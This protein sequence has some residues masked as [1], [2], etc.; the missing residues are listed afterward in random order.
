M[1]FDW[2]EFDGLEWLLALAIPIAAALTAMWVFNALMISRRRDELRQ[3]DENRESEYS[4]WCEGVRAHGGI[5]PVFCPVTLEEG[6]RCFSFDCSVAL[7]LPSEPHEHHGEEVIFDTEPGQPVGGGWSILDCF[8][9]V[10]RVG[11][12]QLCVTN[13]CI[14]FG[15]CGSQQKIMLED[16]HTVAASRSCLLVGSDQMDRPM[17]FQDVNGQRLRDVIHYVLE[18]T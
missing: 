10:R 16:V 3:I 18:E 2:L 15:S 1:E 14:S 4:F 5:Q 17:L 11:C 9:Q 7:Y 8:H 12:G 6:E 13:R